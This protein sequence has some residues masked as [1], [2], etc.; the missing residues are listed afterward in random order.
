M[1]LTTHQIPEL[2]AVHRFPN[3]RRGPAEA[4]HFVTETLRTWGCTPLVDD[5]AVIASELATNA[6]LHARTDFTVT[7]SR[8]AS[9]VRIAVRDASCDPPKRRRGKPSAPSGRGLRLVEALASDWGTDFRA[10]GKVVWAQLLT[11]R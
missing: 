11:R 3:H 8:R 5:A 9:V 10:D 7:V 4:R 6:M 2:E 1:S